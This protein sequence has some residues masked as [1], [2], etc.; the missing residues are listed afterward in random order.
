MLCT[1]DGGE[2]TSRTNITRTE[3]S[4]DVVERYSAVLGR[5]KIGIS[6]YGAESQ[7]LEVW[8]ADIDG[9]SVQVEGS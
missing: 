4:L 3:E 7:G 9:G 2:Q 1:E 6:L 8:E 5:F